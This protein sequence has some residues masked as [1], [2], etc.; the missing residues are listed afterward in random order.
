MSN[1]NILRLKRMLEVL[2]QKANKYG[3]YRAK[4]G[5]F[6]V[7]LVVIN[8]PLYGR[9][10]VTYQLVCSNPYFPEILLSDTYDLYALKHVLTQVVLDDIGRFFDEWRYIAVTNTIT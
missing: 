7:S 8:K 6:K 9:D 5:C 10:Y 4:F 2:L 3:I 1:R